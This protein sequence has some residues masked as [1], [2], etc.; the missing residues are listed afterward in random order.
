MMGHL[1]IVHFWDFLQDRK[2]ESSSGAL[3]T[4]FSL[5]VCM[6]SY[7]FSTRWIEYTLDVGG[8]E[9]QL[10]PLHVSMLMQGIISDQLRDGRTSCCVFERDKGFSA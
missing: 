5:F 7:F 9:K 1:I 10:C 8:L 3:A 6:T 4:L 2:R